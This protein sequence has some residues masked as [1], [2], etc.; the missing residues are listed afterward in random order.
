MRDTAENTEHRSWVSS[1][2]LRHSKISFIGSS[3]NA[4]LGRE[5]PGNTN[6]PTTSTAHL[7]AVFHSLPD[8]SLRAHSPLHEDQCVRN[9]KIMKVGIF[10]NTLGAQTLKGTEPP[11]STTI[12]SEPDSG[13][14]VIVFEG[15]KRQQTLLAPRSK[16]PEEHFTSP[17]SA[18]SSMAN[19][20]NVPT[21][22]VANTSSQRGKHKSYPGTR[23]NSS[24][25]HHRLHNDEIRPFPRSKRSTEYEDIIID[26]A[27]NCKTHDMSLDSP[28]RVQSLQ[29]KNIRSE[30]EFVDTVSERFVVKPSASQPDETKHKNLQILGTSN[31]AGDHGLQ[32]MS[33]R[34][35][36]CDV[37]HLVA[38]EGEVVDAPS[39]ASLIQL[40]TP[41]A[42]E[43][44]ETYECAEATEDVLTSEHGSTQDTSDIEKLAMEDVAEDMQDLIDSEGAFDRAIEGM[45]HSQIAR[46]LSKQEELGLGSDELMIFDGLDFGLI[47]RTKA[48][49]RIFHGRR[50]DS[51]LPKSGRAQ[52]SMT[53]NGV[54]QEIPLAGPYGDF[55]IMDFERPSL[56]RKTNGRKGAP[57]PITDEEL[58]KAMQNAWNNDR[59]KKKLRKEVR[60]EVRRQ[61]LLGKKSDTNMTSNYREGITASQLKV[62]IRSFLLSNYER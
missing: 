62:E 26:H 27:E 61:G 4:C 20:G 17:I 58:D 14:E 8:S 12:L 24:D 1:Q 50:T 2:Q 57:P 6:L 28:I 37:Q 36:R 41:E 13:E 30:E 59:A 45:T 42:R 23:S 7:P 48:S 54:A 44:T 38:R 49:K 3:E 10:T 47:G 52:K 15:R 31:V 25:P 43:A 22:E 33:K 35:R 19:G 16:M 53:L 60:E 18:N 11:S 9:E 39:W 40:I 51:V 5:G 55:D 29:Y 32:I 46:L 56:Q 34:D 21:K